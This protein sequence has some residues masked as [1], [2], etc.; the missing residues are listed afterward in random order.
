MSDPFD[1]LKHLD[2]GPARPALPASEVRRR[3]DRMRRR[4][5]AMQALG[6]TL[7]VVTIVGGGFAV[8]GELTD[9]ARPVP[10]PASQGPSPVDP[11]PEDDWRTAIPADFPLDQGFP[12]ADFSESELTPPGPDVQP[13][14]YVEACEK[15][16][17]PTIQAREGLGTVFQQPEDMRSRL[18]TTYADA[19]EA[20]G[21]LTAV[22]QGFDACP[23]ES[24]GGV[25][26]SVAL[27]EVRET[28]VGDEG[29]AIVRTYESGG[30]PAIGL[31]QIHVVR[32]GNALLLLSTS[33]EGGGTKQDV[34]RQV[35]EQTAQ[36]QAL[37]EAMCIFSLAGCSEDPAPVEEQT[38]LQ[39]ALLGLDTIRDLTSQLATD[40]AE[41]DNRDDP[42]LDCQADFLATLGAK[43]SA[44]REF[45]G[46]AGSKS[47][48]NA[49]AAT[50][51][52]EFEDEAAAGA[53][54][55]K[56]NGW[57]QSCQDRM[58]GTRPVTVAHDPVFQAT[59]FGPA[60][61][62]VVESPAP[63]ICTECDT[64]WI[65]AQGVALVGTRVGLL[66]IA[67][68]GDQMS[69]QDTA[70]SP[71]NDGIKALANAAAGSPGPDESASTVFGP[72]GMAGL[73]LGM[74]TWEA[75]AASMVR[76]LSGGGDCD[77]FVV[78]DLPPLPR[79]RSADGYASENL[80][81]MA[82]FARK[83]MTTA[84][85]VALGASEEQVRAAYPDAEQ[86]VHGWSVPVSGFP[87]RNY[88]LLFEDGKLVELI[89][90]LDNQNC[91]G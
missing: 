4:R 36:T 22:V 20:H 21:V 9:G 44:Y 25:P 46:T 42:T 16:V 66:S 84:E 82:L 48:V 29:Y 83:G 31:G 67:Y 45:Q 40:W 50:A 75:P 63:E 80:G 89:L 77:A 62:R 90:A 49:E 28:G 68:T 70:S 55:D 13:F 52:L 91:Y 19:D 26:E 5:G 35:E 72:Q 18:L 58:E 43:D 65:D 38:P 3:G 88:E 2:E 76:V 47:I 1:T 59:G 61:W 41:V 39:R 34:E 86:G 33:N 12:E 15:G 79:T 32:V 8:G 74:Y 6:A 54:F 73:E 10:P 69:G 71:L 24:Y 53:A 60:A 37:A 17:F 81:I 14:E 56:V 57:L 51:V 11:K 64:G 85:G 30:H 78:K 87:D 23:R 27:T 7:A